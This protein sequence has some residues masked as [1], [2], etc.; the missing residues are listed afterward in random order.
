MTD[1]HFTSDKSTHL[2]GANSLLQKLVPSNHATITNH[3]LCMA[4]AVVAKKGL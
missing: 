1:Q 2:D 4:L 3:H